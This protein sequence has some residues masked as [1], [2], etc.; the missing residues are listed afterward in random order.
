MK[1]FSKYITEGC[2]TADVNQG[3]A[4][5]NTGVMNHLTP[6]ANIVTQ[7]RNLWSP[8]T[9]IVAAVAEDGFSV[10]LNSSKFVSQEEVN[11][12]LYDTTIMRGTSLASYIQQQGLTVV[13]M[14]NIGQFFVVYF[15]PNDI[16]NAGKVE[17]K[18]A[19]LP[20][21]E[22]QDMNIEETEMYTIIKEGDDDE[23][24]KDITREKVVELINSKDKVKAAKQLELLVAQELELPREYYFAGVKSKDGDE[25]IALR[26]KYTKK[27]R[28]DKTIE[29]VRSIINIYDMTKD[30]IWVQD[31]DKDSLVKLPEEVEKLIKTILD[32]LG[33]SETDNPAVYSLAEEDKKTEK[34]KDDDD[35]DKKDKDEED[36]KEEDNKEDEKK[37]SSDKKDD[38]DKD[39]DDEDNSDDLM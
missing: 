24:L 12:I 1:R 8:T 33:A 16:K 37:D 21:Q 7:I 18:P 39:K 13:K 11:K 30:G 38:E 5:S 31:F 15:C 26:W 23:E 9:G 35:D 32:F 6:V 2:V 28:H 22:M 25:S 36:N 4:Y 14:I 20:C 34:K 10:K 27:R 3:N 17:E 19:N 29:N